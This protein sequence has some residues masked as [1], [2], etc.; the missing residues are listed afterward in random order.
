MARIFKKESD[1]IEWVISEDA[2][3]IVSAT[4][5]LVEFKL[6]EP[7]GVRLNSIPA[8]VWALWMQQE[9]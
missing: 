7:V 3:G 5:R 6:S 2:K 4:K 8:E 1:G 9:G